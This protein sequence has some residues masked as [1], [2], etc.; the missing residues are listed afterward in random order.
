MSALGLP[1]SSTTHVLAKCLHFAQKVLVIK[2]LLFL[3]IK[4]LHKAKALALQISISDAGF[5]IL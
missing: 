1:P 5:D 3:P 2:D 4:Q